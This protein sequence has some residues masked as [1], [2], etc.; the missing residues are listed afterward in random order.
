[1]Q[2]SDLVNKLGNFVNRTLK[3]KGIEN[4]KVNKIDKEVEEKIT[5][6]YKNFEAYVKTLEFKKAVEEIMSLV[7]FGNKYYDDNK[8]WVLFKE[9]KEE[10]DK[11]MY[12]CETII[13]NLANLF[14]PIMP[15]TANKIAKYVNVKLDKFE[16][17]KI[18][19]D[20]AIENVEPLFEKIK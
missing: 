8:P 18:E 9:N 13:A 10:F 15:E 20:L 19:K 14:E 5:L 17:I 16:M 12:N 2:N 7:E 3:F 1:M 4:I 11:V 6:T